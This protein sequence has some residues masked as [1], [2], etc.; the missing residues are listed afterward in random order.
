MHAQHQYLPQQHRQQHILLGSV[1]IQQQLHQQHHV[2]CFQIVSHLRH[3]AIIHQVILRVHSLDHTAQCFAVFAETAVATVLLASFFKQNFELNNAPPAP[4]LS[5]NLPQD[6]LP[7]WI[8]PLPMSQQAQAVYHCQIALSAL[9]V[10]SIRLLEVVLLVESASTSLIQPP[11]PAWTV[12][13]AKPPMAPAL[14][15]YQAAL[16]ALLVLIMSVIPGPSLQGVMFV[17]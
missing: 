11:P 7:A 13:L 10:I 1:L 16:A 17:Q 9:L 8:A 4:C 2:D 5:T 6:P 14:P 12:P 15:C 3:S